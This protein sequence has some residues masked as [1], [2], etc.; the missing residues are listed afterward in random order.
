MTRRSRGARTLIQ[1]FLNFAILP[2][3]VHR[4]P[5]HLCSAVWDV[6]LSR[7]PLLCRKVD[8]GVSAGNT[9][10]GSTGA[11]DPGRAAVSAGNRL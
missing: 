5:R 9:T 3:A 4:R 7:E 6:H 1:S 2:L 11:R 8:P 10:Q